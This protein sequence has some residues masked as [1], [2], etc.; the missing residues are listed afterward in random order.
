MWHGTGRDDD[1]VE[2]L[3]LGTSCLYV[4]GTGTTSRG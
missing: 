1:W 3:A 2:G 4:A